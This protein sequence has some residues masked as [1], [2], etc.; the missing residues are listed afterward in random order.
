MLN[1]AY[2][3]CVGLFPLKASSGTKVAELPDKFANYEWDLSDSIIPVTYDFTNINIGGT[4]IESIEKATITD[5]SKAKSYDSGSVTPPTVNFATISPI[6]SETIVDTLNALGQTVSDPFK[7]LLCVGKY[8]GTSSGVRSYDIFHEA[9]CLLLQ[10][11][12][13]NG[14]AHQKFTGGLQFQECH[15][16]IIGET[17]TAAK[18]TLTE[19]T[20]AIAYSHNV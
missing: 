10:D 15:L 4:Q 20:N 1:F 9:C 6:D 12:E 13:R 2:Q 7:C 18:L 14:E 11:G 16:P 3:I 8:T 5:L 17:K 19:A